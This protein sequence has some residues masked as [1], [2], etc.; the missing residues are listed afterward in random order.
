MRA[1]KTVRGNFHPAKMDLGYDVRRR[2][3]SEC[4]G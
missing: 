2:N 4:A 1:Q 3:F